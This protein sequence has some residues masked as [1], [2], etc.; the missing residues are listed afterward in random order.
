L[1]L[2][3]AAACG[4]SYEP[5]LSHCKAYAPYERAVRQWFQFLQ[6]HEK[7]FRGQSSFAD[8]G[9]VCSLSGI[10]VGLPTPFYECL[11]QLEAA[12]VPFAALLTEQ[13]MSNCLSEKYRCVLLPQTPMLSDAEAAALLHFVRSGGALVLIGPSGEYDQ[14]GA[15]RKTPVLRQLYAALGGNSYAN[16][17]RGKLAHVQSP[18]AALGDLVR[19]MRNADPLVTV[20]GGEFVR[21]TLMHRRDPPA[22]L[23]NVL[24]YDVGI[25]RALTPAK[26]VE[27]DLELPPGRTPTSVTALSPTSDPQR[28]T[29]QL[30]PSGS[31]LR[32]LIQAPEV[33][34]YTGVLVELR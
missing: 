2:A 10:Y 19:K 31:V 6:K 23:V 24:N 25:D 16:L 5:H 12:R 8:V 26:N 30:A 28:L 3:E 17:G 33:F 34:V 29:F 15:K 9:V 21:T 32:L 14:R 4:V 1:Q 22:I 11:D 18:D 20:S 7:A 27:I 13:L